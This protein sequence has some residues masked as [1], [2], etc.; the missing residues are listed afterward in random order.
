[1]VYDGNMKRIFVGIPIFSPMLL[2]YAPGLR[3]QKGMK[4]IAPKNLHITLVPPWDETN[5]ES[6]KNALPGIYFQAFSILFNKVTFGPSL[7]EP[8][9][10]WAVGEAPR[11]I[12][13]L[14]LKIFGLLHKEPDK[15]PFKLHA[16]LGRFKPEH[17]KKFAA[18]D[19]DERIHWEQAVTSI[20]LY[21][22]RL[23]SQGSDYKILSEIF[24]QK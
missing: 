15:R 6:V 23:L 24:L 12:L 20:V 22:S 21:E 3:K 14:R 17:F 5:V 13:D 1:M 2:T 10:V 16:T 11:Q 19:L 9:M 4:W 18:R 7:R 8:R